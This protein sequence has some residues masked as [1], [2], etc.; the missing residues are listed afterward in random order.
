MTNSFI[1]FQYMTK[2]TAVTIEIQYA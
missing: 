2:H 1:Q